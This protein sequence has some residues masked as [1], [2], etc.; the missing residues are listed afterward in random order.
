MKKRRKATSRGTS[1]RRKAAARGP[2][3]RTASSSLRI[4]LSDARGRLSDTVNRVAYAKDRI[5]LHRHGKDLVAIVPVEDLERLRELED[6]LDIEAA[7]AALR[8]SGGRPHE[9]VRRRLDL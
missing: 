2:G 6:L 9:E 4:A 7:R 8:E 5:T 1:S 3:A